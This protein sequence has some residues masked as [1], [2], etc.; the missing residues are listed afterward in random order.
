MTDR[1]DRKERPNTSS[2]QGEAESAEFV[3]GSKTASPISDDDAE[4]DSET[5]DPL[6]VEETVQLSMTRS[7]EELS[8]SKS[9][10]VAI[11]P[12]T[13][14]ISR[15]P[16]LPV[17]SSPETV[18]SGI[19]PMSPI[20]AN[21]SKISPHSVEVRRISERARSNTQSK[22]SHKDQRGQTHL[23]SQSLTVTRKPDVIS[24]ETR[25]S[26]SL[27]LARV[28]GGQALL[29]EIEEIDPVF[30]WSGGLPYGTNRPT[31]ILHCA[32]KGI[33]SFSFLQRC[34]RDT[35]AELE[36]GE[37]T[38]EP[39]EF[40]ANEP[41]VPIVGG[42][43]VTLDLTEGD[44]SPSV[45]GDRP[46]I[47]R[48]G[49]DIVPTLVE[50]AQTLYSGGLGYAVVNLPS[51]WEGTF[52]RSQFF[53]TLV[54]YITE[55]SS[56]ETSSTKETGTLE[57]LRTA[58]VTIARPRITDADAFD[59][60]VALYFGFETV[61]WETIPQAD[62]AFLNLLRSEHWTQVALTERQ[63]YGE[64]SSRH[65]NW[66]GLLT[67][68]IA[69][70]LWIA[71]TDGETPFNNF[72][73][74]SLRSTDLLQTEYPLG[75]SD[76]DDAVAIADIHLENNRDWVPEAVAAFTPD[77]E[78][79]S[80]L[81]IEFETGFSEGAFQHRKLVESIEKYESIT[82]VE[83]IL[84]AIP[85]RLLY[86]GERQAR[87]LN[88]LVDSEDDRLE[89]T[90]AEL[91]VPVLAQGSCTGVQRATKIIETLYNND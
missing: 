14:T 86:R 5:D 1:E 69:R 75:D 44:W 15:N 51:E 30:G 74:Q 61:D 38:V 76:P 48:G 27:S 90:T 56:P 80:P 4:S 42:R 79:E 34:L 58:P 17:R 36:G 3:S 66:K 81:V 83:T 57:Q 35:Y 18:V 37:P 64:E 49:I 70:Q 2:K 91:C 10:R 77:G 11:N 41:Q 16:S 71:A 12:A 47:E 68:G 87:L 7:E 88:Q 29:D 54:D 9:L 72:V 24:S 28:Q 59:A 62:T 52:R 23:D 33:S 50:L 20:T 60:R 55:A 85:P 46:T 84:L 67:E 25:P 8:D 89:N 32:E 63:S 39:V 45:S 6:T 73:Q 53:A 13:P 26:T 21:T 31:L 43:I 78:Y 82:S 40:V 19:S 65:Y 22:I